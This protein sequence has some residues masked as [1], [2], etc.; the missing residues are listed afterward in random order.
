[1]AM[2]N[3][4]V[5][6]PEERI[7]EFYAVHAAWLATPDPEASLEAPEASGG[8]SGE[9]E[10]TQATGWNLPYWTGEDEALAREV[11]GKLSEPAKRLVSALIDSPNRQF[12]GDELAAIADI[13]H[14]KQGVAGALGWPGR[15]CFKVGRRW[16][17]LWGYP[18][19]NAVYWVEPDVAAVF[20]QARDRN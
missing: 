16:F 17:W 11:W 5:L 10:A 7:S 20:V 9:G 18:N 14:G 12:D 2:V 15:H 13:P 8:V 19:G 6:V 3:V 4:S 1:M